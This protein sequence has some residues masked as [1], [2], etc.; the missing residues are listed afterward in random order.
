MGREIKLTEYFEEVETEVE[1]NRY[2]YRVGEALTMPL[3]IISAQLAE[4]GI[5]LGQ[6][7]VGGKSNEI[8]AVRDLL[9]L[10]NVEGC[11]IVADK[12]P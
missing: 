11:V 4:L 5:T 9:C 12:A 7:T 3:H 1:Y 10:L 2:F 6:R 8:P